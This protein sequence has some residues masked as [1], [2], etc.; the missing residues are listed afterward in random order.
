MVELFISLLYE[1]TL[2][3]PR[4]LSHLFSIRYISLLLLNH[5]F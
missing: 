1:L 2:V 3:L 4:Y 5:N